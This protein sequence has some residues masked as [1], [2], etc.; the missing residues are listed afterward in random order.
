MPDTD[1]MMTITSSVMLLNIIIFTDT[2]HLSI[3]LIRTSVRSMELEIY[4]LATAA[5]SPKNVNAFKMYPNCRYL[6]KSIRYSSARCYC[7]M[8]PA[9][10]LNSLLA[11]QRRLLTIAQLSI[12]IVTRGRSSHQPSPAQPGDPR[13]L[14]PI[15]CEMCEQRPVYL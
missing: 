11:T 8:S 10:Y 5:T 7:L 6:F 2:K 12:V 13:L 3:F 9:Q 14:F 4:E 1:T 15:N